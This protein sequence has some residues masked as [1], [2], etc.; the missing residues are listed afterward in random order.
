MSL[1][2]LALASV[3]THAQT[4]S[5]TPRWGGFYSAGKNASIF[6]SPVV[7][8]DHTIYFGVEYSTTP[9][10]GLVLALTSA[11]VEKWQFPKAGAPPIEEVEAGLALSP[12][13]TTLYAPCTD[14]RVYVLDAQT[15]ALKGTADAGRA[16]AIY[17]TPAV[18]KDGTVYFGA[19]YLGDIISQ[20]DSLFY[21]MDRNG[22]VLW[23]T[24][25]AGLVDSSPAI[26]T[27]G[28][29]YVGAGKVFYAFSP[30]GGRPKW[31]R[32][33]AGA[34]HASP[35]ISWDGTIYVG[36]D[37][38]DFYALTPQN[39]IKWT[40]SAAPG[41]GIAIAA[42]D[43]VYVGTTDGWMFAFGPDGSARK[44]W[45][46]NIQS[47]VLS[48]PA[49]RSDG[50]I[51]FGIGSTLGSDVKA[52]DA[53]NPDGTKKWDFKVSDAVEASPVIDTDGS[54]YFGTVGG[55]FYSLPGSG[56]GVSP[57]ASWPMLG[58]DILHSG[59]AV[60][61][62]RGGRLINL[63]TRGPAG[64][65]T[66]LI[67][68]F[69]VQGTGLKPLLIRAV[70]PTLGIY[71]IAVPLPNPALTVHVTSSFTA[72]Y[73]DDWG[74]SDDA[75][76]IASTAPQVGAFPLL[77][78]SKDA[79]V[80][81]QAIAGESTTYSTTVES[82]GGG[83]GVA[84][85]ETYDVT[86]RSPAAL[87]INLSARGQVGTGENVLIP[88]LVVGGDGQLRVLI[89]AVGPGLKRFNVAAPIAQPS[90]AVFNRQAVKFGANTGWT[91]GGLK[92]DLAGAAALSGAFPL[93]ETDADSA[94]ILTL[95]PGDYTF[96][97]AGVGGGT[98]EALVEVYALPH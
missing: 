74:S 37:G 62:V 92:G 54:I 67:A 81:A 32:T 11:G 69:V 41:A 98:G 72:Y 55:K 77:A 47:P 52:V 57:Y 34:M 46:V 70:G 95:D 39:E 88:G 31:T 40:A 4:E 58:Q 28:T 80:L 43:T 66:N 50:T 97:V 30:A 16:S 71:G 14:G 94:M 59:R 13:G 51:I 87:L 82:V 84:M 17:S 48:V 78:N 18:A 76:L 49:I 91:S 45:P 35:A 2:M 22:T 29:I 86:P 56:A 53:Y 83:S 10:T 7:G 12:D 44:G 26:G 1:A 60:V 85:V 79:A 20:E 8:P 96:Q 6:S 61:P 19:T 5:T 21:A 89:R 65:G 68:G 36:S 33:M 24:S 9:G 75:A 64:P 63:A 15:G 25:I 3:V 42:D 27:D 23:S 90:I 38:G 73:N 93:L